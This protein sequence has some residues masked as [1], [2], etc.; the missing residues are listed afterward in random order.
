MRRLLDDEG[1]GLVE[2]ALLITLIVVVAIIAVS[3]TG[4]ETTSMWD[5]IS[6]GIR[7]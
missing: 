5:D 6:S 7:P 1:A 2:Y 4:Q 3:F